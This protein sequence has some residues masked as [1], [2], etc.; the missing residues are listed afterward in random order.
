MKGGNEHASMDYWTSDGDRSTRCSGS[1]NRIHHQ[2][3]GSRACGD[4]GHSDLDRHRKSS[5]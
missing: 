1:D 4:L 3:S 5:I 2:G